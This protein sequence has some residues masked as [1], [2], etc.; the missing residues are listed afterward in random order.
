MAIRDHIGHRG[1][2]IFRVLITRFCY[3]RFYF[4]EVFLGEKHET[5][6]FAVE[7]ID[8]SCAGA[9]FYVQVKS[10][11]RGYTGDGGDKLLNVSLRKRDINKLR[12]VPGPAFLV[13]ID[14][15]EERGYIR[16]ITA[17]TDGAISGLTTRHPLNCRTIRALWEEVDSYWIARTMLQPGSHFEA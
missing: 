14:V 4:R 10:T 11:M 17:S 6:D 3:A 7:L 5:T 15:R 13:G 9:C 8:P 16:A 2:N 12:R 1:E